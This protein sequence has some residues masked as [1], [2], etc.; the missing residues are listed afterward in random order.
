M[1]EGFDLAAY[2]KSST[3]KSGVPL[4]LKNKNVMRALARLLK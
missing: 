4:R 3:K 2:M 1:K